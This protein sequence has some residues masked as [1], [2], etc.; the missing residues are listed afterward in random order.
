MTTAYGLRRQ[1]VISLALMAISIALLFLLGS[2]AL[3]A[4]LMNYSPSSISY[5]AMP[6]PIEAMWMLGTLLAALVLAVG[7][8]VKLS[9]R[10][11]APLNSVAR[12]LRHIAEGDLSARAATDEHAVGETAQ[13][14]KDF[15]GMAERLQ[16]MAQERA[17][18]NAAIA[19]ELR[20]PV[21]ILRGRLQG[22]TEGVFEPTPAQFQGLLKNVEGLARLIEDLRLLG[23]SDSGHLDVRLEL[24]D[25]CAEVCAVA[26]AFEQRFQAAGFT[27]ALELEPLEAPC[28]PVRIRQAL[29]ALLENTLRHA[30][31]GHVVIRAW[32]DGH[33]CHLLVEDSGPGIVEADPG[34]LFEAFQRGDSS[35]GRPGSGLGLA[36]VQAIAQAHGGQATWSP[37][38]LGGSAFQLAWP[39]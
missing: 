39:I 10:I 17:F 25:L 2:Y 35:H 1:L 8:A 7:I 24:A 32:Q 13:L 33:A 21:T 3:Y 27:L 36:V 9:R 22:L 15:N 20:T 23:L 14:V 18:W 11:V 34:R 31:P 4:L 12:S 6:S 19:H 30:T 29:M 16:H 5:D 37:S 26:Q 28:E 38:R